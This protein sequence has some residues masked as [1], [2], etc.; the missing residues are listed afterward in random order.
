MSKKILTVTPFFPPDKSGIAN[1]VL[2]LNLNLVKQGY[3]ISIIAP[4]HLGD[5][6]SAADNN[7]RQIFRINS[8][9]LPGWPYHS[10]KSMSIPTDF[11]LKIRSIIQ[12]GNFDVVHAHGHHY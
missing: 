3:D 4:K 9:Y 10:L 1:H 8:F 2:N 5:K 12:N 6:L 7:F 11:G